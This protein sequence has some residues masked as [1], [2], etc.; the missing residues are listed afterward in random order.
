MYAVLPIENAIVQ[1]LV[2]L[3]KSA[4]WVHWS[5]VG[6][7]FQISFLPLSP[8]GENPIPTYP[9]KT[10]GICSPTLLQNELPKS[11]DHL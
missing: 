11:I 7:Y 5:V 1:L 3:S 6:S 4:L 2:P 9:Y 8:D 10:Y